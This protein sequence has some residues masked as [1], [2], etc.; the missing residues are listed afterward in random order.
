VDLL[1]VA[2]VG[3]GPYGLSLAAHLAAKIR[4][5]RVFGAPMRTWRTMMPPE[6]L[7]RSHWTETRLSAP[8]D[9]GTLQCWA[10]AVGGEKIEPVPLQSFLRYADWFR[11]QFVPEVDDADITSVERANGTFRLR[12]AAGDELDARRI[13]AAV[14]V[15]PF[16]RRL[17]QLAELEEAGRVSLAIEHQ[18]FGRFAGQR[19]LV[20]GGGQNGLESAALAHAAGAESVEVAV[21]SEVRWFRQREHWEAR[22]WAHER[23]FRLAYPIVGFGPPPINRLVLHPDLFSN[24]PVTV[25]ERLNTRLLRPG[26]SPWVRDQVEG[27]IPVTVGVTVA[28]AQERGGEVIVRLSDGTQREV[29]HLI[30]C[31][32][33]R[34]DLDALRFIDPALREAIEIDDGWP[35][36]DRAFRSRSV[37]ELS[38]IGYAAE[39]RFGPLSRFVAGTTFTSQRAASV[40]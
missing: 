35:A 17:T 11:E 34:F 31:V 16:P 7:L 37:P 20:V 9:R 23:L 40:L 5:V 4:S 8:N 26:G 24:L 1:D 18:Q 36:L 21:R 33:Y 13:V 32:G 10:D 30:V 27:Q 28:E 29:D 15:T 2:V 19:V 12:T 14:G 6:M 38:F 22:G 3:A 39:H 25:R